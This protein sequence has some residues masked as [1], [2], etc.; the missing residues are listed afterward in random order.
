MQRNPVETWPRAVYE[1]PW[2]VRVWNNFTVVYACDP[3]LLK[4]VLLDAVEDFPKAAIEER[5]LKP[6]FGEGM[7]TSEGDTWKQQ[8]R[9][10]ASGFRR[11]ALNAMVPAMVAAGEAAADRLLGRLAASPTT[12][13]Q[14]G[15]KNGAKCVEDVCVETTRA[16]LDVIMAML[17]GGDN[18]PVDKTEIARDTATY[19][20]TIGRIGLSDIFD[21]PKWWP[22]LEQKRGRAAVARMHAAIN[23]LIAQRRASGQSQPDLLSLL[24][25][26]RDPVSGEGFSDAVV[27]DNVMTFVGAGHETTSLAL[28][29]ALWL[30]AHDPQTQDKLAAEA[31]QVLGDGPIEARHIDSLVWHRAVLEEAMRLFPPVATVPRQAKREMTFTSPSHSGATLTIPKGALVLCAIYATH[32]HSLYWPEPDSFIPERFLPEKRQEAAAF[33]LGASPASRHRYYYMPFGAGPRVCI[34]QQFALM[35]GVSILAAIVRKLRVAPVP[36]HFLD[37]RVRITMRNVDGLP[38]EFQARTP[39]PRPEAATVFSDD[40]HMPDVDLERV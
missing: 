37:L 18:G 31:E 22:K 39:T 13:A 27:R 2:F 15:P 36:G 21:L 28:G 16:T 8:R 25:D 14:S 5:V 12:P 11:D 29:W 40:G 23:A 7:L 3:D 20:D 34:G 1:Q 38:L 33:T 35:E 9:A 30:L 19:L 4:F 6:A 32:R 10:V 26:A 24:L 17:F